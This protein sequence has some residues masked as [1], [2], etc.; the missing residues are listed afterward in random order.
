MKKDNSE[1]DVD[2]EPKKSKKNKATS[3][4]VPNRSMRRGKRK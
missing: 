4:I 2:F 1:E 3:E